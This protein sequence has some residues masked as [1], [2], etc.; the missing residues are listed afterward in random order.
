MRASN[1]LRIT[2]FAFDSRMPLPPC[3]ALRLPLISSKIGKDVWQSR[4]SQF[5][6]LKIRR[7]PKART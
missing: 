4:E 1:M 5:I 6:L 7:I 3:A 2:Q